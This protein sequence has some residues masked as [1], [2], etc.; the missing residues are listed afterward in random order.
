MRKTQTSILAIIFA[1][2]LLLPAC[3]VKKLESRLDPVSEEFYSK[4]RYIITS[5]EAKIFLELPPQER[6]EFI[7]DFWK[8]RDPSPGT[9]ANELKE[10]YYSRI[11]E[12]NRLFKG[13]GRPGWLQ[14]RG[15]IYVLF[16]PPD[17]RQTN[18]MGG[19]PIDAYVDPSEMTGS[20]RVATGE[21][22]TE[23]WVYRNLFSSL[24][25][26]HVV[27]LIFVDTYGTGDYKLT[28]NLDEALPGTMGIETEFAPNLALTHELRKE[29]A[30]RA[31]LHLQRA[32]FNFSWEFIKRKDKKLRS[33]LL[34][35][36]A[37]PFQKILFAKEEN[38]LKAK[39]EMMIQIKIED[40]IIW[41][42]REEYDLN[43]RE[44]TLQQ[45]KGMDWEKDIPVTEWLKKGDYSVYMRLR[46][47]TG[48]QEIEKLLP[49]NM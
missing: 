34:I 13:G 5:E 42:F 46:N 11:E 41:Q 31:K 49:L 36:T 23:I 24:Q 37:L 4:V 32:L 43:Y 12:A 18:P 7:Q 15:R 27:R 39:L 25:R 38:R 1:L 17:E 35:H 8:R 47:L 28:T 26:P 22:P 44:E 48:D 40:N 16:G 10:V 20:R 14:D 33:N 30:A 29:E 2:A 45:M 21:K 9:E 3:A 19:R 6:P